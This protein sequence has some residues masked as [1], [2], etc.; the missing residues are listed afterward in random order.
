MRGFI[1]INAKGRHKAG[2]CYPIKFNYHFYFITT[3][4]MILL[5]LSEAIFTK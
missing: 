3:S 4:L 1:D 2:P 5:A